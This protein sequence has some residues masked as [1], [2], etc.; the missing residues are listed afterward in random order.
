M[1]NAATPSV[2][3]QHR[4]LR[5][6]SMR[7]LL[8][9]FMVLNHFPTDLR[10]FTDGF[11]GVFS[12]A[13]GF[14]FLSGILAGWVYTRRL[15]RNGPAA[16]KTAA[17]NRARVIYFWHLASF[18]TAVGA[19]LLF[20]HLRQLCASTSP[21]LFYENPLLALLLGICLLHQ[22]GLLDIL[23]MYCLFVLL[24]PPVLRALEKGRHVRVLAV[25]FAIWLCVQNAPPIDGAPL[26][27][28]NVG[29]FNLLAWQ[30]LFIGGLL[31]GHD[32]ARRTGPASAPHSLVTMAAIA[33]VVYGI[34]L[35]HW[36]WPQPWPDA[37]FGIMLNKPALGWLRLTD[38]LCMAFLIGEAGRRWPRVLH[39]PALEF[40]GRHSISI[41]AVQSVVIIVLLQFP[42]LFR[43][44]TNRWL[45]TAGVIAMIYATAAVDN[46]VR[47]ALLRRRG[48]GTRQPSELPANQAHGVRAA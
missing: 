44:A 2:P 29:S 24:I 3:F 39:W 10:L 33:I 19:V 32:R 5:F 18:V 1:S 8:L 12:S 28:I 20:C 31:I 35:R 23:P 43:T 25:S 41:V 22:P 46:A 15:L 37:I 47:L 13:E 36:H 48:V 34:G 40:L 30:F 14:V 11:F 45:T 21:Q 4:D 7:G 17:V 26:D 42:V 38:F 16:L 6:D 9:V 27:P